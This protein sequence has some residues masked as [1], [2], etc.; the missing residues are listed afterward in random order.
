LARQSN[1]RNNLHTV[2]HFRLRS[3][4]KIF[5]RLSWNKLTKSYAHFRKNEHFVRK[6]I[7]FRNSKT[8]RECRENFAKK[9][10]FA[11]RKFSKNGTFSR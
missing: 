2:L 9:K 6:L 10:N 8:F 11:N 5:L 3:R 1:W 4:A 7:S